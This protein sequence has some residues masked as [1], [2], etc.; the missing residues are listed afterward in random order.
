MMKAEGGTEPGS[1]TM[2]AKK[3]REVLYNEEVE[4][5]ILEPALISKNDALLETLKW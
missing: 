2:A 4:A 5:R 3:I 1:D